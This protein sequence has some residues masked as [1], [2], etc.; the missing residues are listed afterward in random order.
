MADPIDLTRF[1]LHLG[2]GATT[3][4]QP[5]FDGDVAWYGGYMQRHS[6]D[7]IEGRLVAMHSF[8]E[9][10]DVW[11]MHPLGTEVVLCV[12][13]SITLIQEI[14]GEEV[15]TTLGTGEAA[16]NHPGTWHT[17]DVNAPTTCVF[18]TAGAGTEHRPR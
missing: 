6:N 9:S 3:V 14:D 2:L 4:P 12:A 11:E 15:P 1:P 13:G 10:W 5:E 18:I 7:G 8:T 16:I 17:A